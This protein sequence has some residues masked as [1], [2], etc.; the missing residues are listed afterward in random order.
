M[1]RMELARIIRRPSFWYLCVALFVMQMVIFCFFPQPCEDAAAVNY[2][3]YLEN[4]ESASQRLDQVSIFQG[5]KDGD[6]FSKKNIKKSAVDHA[7]L[8]DITVE[9]GG[10][11]GVTSALKLSETD[12]F[13]LFLSLFGAF[14]LIWEEKS[15]ALFAITRATKRGHLYHIGGK[16]LAL[17]LYVIGVNVTFGLFRIVWYVHGQGFGILTRRLQSVG[18]YMESAIPMHIVGFLLCVIGSRI[19]VCFLCGTFLL[20]ISIWAKQVWLPWMVTLFFLLEEFGRYFGI[21]RHSYLAIIKYSSVAAGMDGASLYGEYNNINW[22]GEPV[23]A[24][25]WVALWIGLWLVIT[26]LT[27]MVSFCVSRQEVTRQSSLLKERRRTYGSSLWSQ[28]WY[29]LLA[30]QKVGILLFLFVGAMLL[31]QAN[32]NYPVSLSEA[33]Y[34]DIMLQLEG[35]V[36]LEKE[37]FLRKE[38]KNYEEAFTHLEQIAQ[39]EERGE[40]DFFTA[41]DMRTKYE[42]I[43]RFYPQFE[44]CEKQY[45]RALR[46]GTPMLYETGYRTLFY[47]NG[48]TKMDIYEWMVSALFL[49]VSLGGVMT[50]EK[51]R[52]AW[53]LIG[54]TETGKREI[55]KTKWKIALTLSAAAGAFAFITRFYEIQKAYPMDGWGMPMEAMS[56]Q[57]MIGGGMLLILAGLFF[58]LLYLLLYC[59]VTAIVLLISNRS[60]QTFLSYLLSF[61]LVIIPMLLTLL[62]L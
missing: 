26:I 41:E 51:E 43:T 4:V 59:G 34:Q 54:A 17:L 2:K 6:A 15:K 36:T 29:K 24:C 25:S 62:F 3:D 32:R 28:E 47:L 58:L 21:S 19:F 12:I 20:F 44:R 38:R 57:S 39:M 31:L 13:V 14:C 48:I 53:K 35:E 61:L 23:W 49:I 5:A 33:Y 52:E 16:I 60:N 27:T 8:A 7:K 30:G 50:M 37:E 11:Y 1:I 56:M 10:I 18:A 42:M 22:L 9:E 45:E 46:V 40:V 55:K